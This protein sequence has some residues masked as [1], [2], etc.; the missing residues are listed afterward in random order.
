MYYSQY[1]SYVHSG[2]VPTDEVI[3]DTQYTVGYLS[4]HLVEQ[5]LINWFVFGIDCALLIVHLSNIGGRYY[6]MRRRVGGNSDVIKYVS[7]EY[8]LQDYWTFIA[9]L[10]EFPGIELLQ[11][12]SYG[13]RG[14][15]YINDIECV[16]VYV[17]IFQFRH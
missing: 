11:S 8:A 16:H 2:P 12:W 4:W 5:L 3:S 13:V 9:A 1:I 6:Y 10:V 17:H 14:Y 7:N 15:E